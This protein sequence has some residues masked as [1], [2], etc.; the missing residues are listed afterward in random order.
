MGAP[1]AVSRQARLDRLRRRARLLGQRERGR[2]RARAGDA[3][4]GQEA[5]ARALGVER[6]EV[7]I[8]AT[9]VIGRELPRDRL[10][11][12]VEAAAAALEDGAAGLSE[13]IMTT[14]RGPKRA[15]LE[16]ELEA[17]RVRLAAQAKGAGMAPAFAAATLFC[18]VETDAA[19]PAPALDALTGVCGNPLVRPHL[20]RRAALHQR[21]RVLLAGERLGRPGRGR[22]GRRRA[23]R[24]GARRAHAPARARDRAPTARAPCAWAGW[25]CGAPATWSS[26][27]PARWP[28]RRS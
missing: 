4:Q 2:R 11:A 17:G 7:G 27:S 1:V 23:P 26:R 22:L 16:V 10:P 19:I 20:G 28:T 15:C 13:A 21:H 18:F 14:D 24:R 9:G 8:A 12:G 3:R 5:A 6:A 25:W